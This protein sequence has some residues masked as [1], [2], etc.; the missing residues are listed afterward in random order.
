MSTSTK[1][2]SSAALI[3][4]E[5]LG[6]VVG[7][8]E[9]GDIIVQSRSGQGRISCHSLDTDHGDSQ[10]SLT[11]FK[12]ADALRF[13]YQFIGIDPLGYGIH[14]KNLS[15]RE[16][17]R[18]TYDS[19]YPDGIIQ[20]W[21]IFNGDRTGD[22]VL[23]AESGYDL[24]ARY[25]IPEHHATHGALIAEHMHIP[26]A[27]NYPIAEQCIRSVDVF[28]TVLSLCGHKVAGHPIDGRIVK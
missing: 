2:G 3:E 13:S 5:G 18:K 7:Q 4:L 14:Y 1:W 26:F 9:T 27:T 21:Q 15:S 19:S 25:E 22:L 6:L 28:P 12:C 10:N 11:P 23:S 8:S 24:R 17:L 16:A 20:L